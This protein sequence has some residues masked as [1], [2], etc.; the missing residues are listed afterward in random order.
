MKYKK[1]AQYSGRFRYW[2][3]E[4]FANLQRSDHVGFSDLCRHEVFDVTPYCVNGFTFII[5]MIQKESTGNWKITEI[6]MLLL[7]GEEGRESG[8]QRA[9]KS[10]FVKARCGDTETGRSPQPAALR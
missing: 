4:N 6:L 10:Q 5:Q 2:L 7:G 9:V 3:P 8:E 1:P